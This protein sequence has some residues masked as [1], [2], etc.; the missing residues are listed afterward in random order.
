MQVKR[1]G[2]GSE[3]LFHNDEPIKTVAWGGGKSDRVGGVG[4]LLKSDNRSSRLRRKGKKEEKLTNC[5]EESQR[6]G[7]KETPTKRKKES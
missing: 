3:E 7:D 4:K 2:K 1:G 6:W 5:V